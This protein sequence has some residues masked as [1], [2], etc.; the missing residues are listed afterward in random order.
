MAAAYLFDLDGTLVDSAP[1]L[2]MAVNHVLVAFKCEPVP[3]MKVRAWV[4]GGARRMLAEGF[5]SAGF[6]QVPEQAHAMLLEYYE[7]H[8][9]D[10][11]VLYAG[12]QEALVA[13]HQEKRPLAVVTNK[14]RYLAVPLL[15]ALGV[16][17]LFTTI[18]GGTCAGKAKPHPEPILLACNRLAV[19]PEDAMMVGDSKYDQAAA[20]AAHTAY[21]E[22]T[23]GYTTTLSDDADRPTPTCIDS[24]LDLL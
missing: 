5:A 1:D 21:C 8:V 9:A 19:A 13:L 24:L 18:I 10:L 23:Y 6:E 17:P 22:V 12:V 15:G 4:G 14:F 3:A 20:L 16:A 7:Q 11:S 2:A